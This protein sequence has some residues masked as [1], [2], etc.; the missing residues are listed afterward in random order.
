MCCHAEFKQDAG[1]SYVI[2]D[3]FANCDSMF[4][5]KWPKR[6][7][8]VI[9]VLSLLGAGF[10][11]FWRAF[12][13]E[14]NVAQSIMLIHVAVADGLMGVYLIAIGAM[15]L[16][17]TGVYYL[18]DFQWRTGL[19][20]R[21]IGGISVFSSEVSIMVLSLLSVDRF[22]HIVFP[23]RFRVLNRKKAHG[24]CLLIW[25]VSFV[26]A[27]L[28]AFEIQYFYDPDKGIFYYGKS[29]VCLPLQLSPKFNAGWEYS[30]VI[31]VGLNLAFVLVII[32]AYIMI[33]FKTWLSKWRLSHQ[34]TRREIQARART[35][36]SRRETSLAKRIVF[37]IL[38][39][40][41]CWSPI[42][43]IGLRSVVDEY[44][45][46]PGDIAVWFAVFVLPFNS[47]INPVLYTFSTPQV[48]AFFSPFDNIDTLHLKTLY[49]VEIQCRSTFIHFK[50]VFS[51]LLP[52]RV[53]TAQTMNKRR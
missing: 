35:A 18:H 21:I 22:K 39:D 44:F 13:K 7:I 10:V 52:H 50:C 34:G 29:V 49:P 43:V 45:H 26:I 2:N 47:A 32:A 31:F 37:I 33:L 3:N 19:S 36:D 23:K 46:I 28:P 25:V 30:V 16:A 1:C 53:N 15:D 38:T 9:G 11:L 6:S 20:C 42:M 24:F 4:R 51:L 17:W 40:V 5:N 48:R 14:K 27:F 41:A 8:W 12:H